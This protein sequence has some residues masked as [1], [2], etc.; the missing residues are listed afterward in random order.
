MASKI[1]KKLNKIGRSKRNN[2][3]NLDMRKVFIEK[4]FDKQLD[5]TEPGNWKI[6]LRVLL[7]CITKR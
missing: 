4:N 5:S 2:V 7:D 6:A 1:R 3:K